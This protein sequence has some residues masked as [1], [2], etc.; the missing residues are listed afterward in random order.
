MNTLLAPLINS[1][2]TPELRR[3]ILITA[4][5]F[6]VFRIFAHLPLP[7]V[8]IMKLRALFAQNQFLGLLDIFSGGT[9]VNFSVMALGLNPYINASIILQLL[10]IV[11]PSLEA[12]SK[13]GDFGRE[14]INQY[15]RFLTVPLAAMQSI[16]MY[17]LLK[18]EGIGHWEEWSGLYNVQD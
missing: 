5:L 12:L 18:N 2:K 1:W 6:I 16:G 15:T 14:K 11:F 10:T 3:K 13:E 17:A 9:L 7:G 8:D 4:F